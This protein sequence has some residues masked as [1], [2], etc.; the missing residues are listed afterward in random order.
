M[1]SIAAL[2]RIGRLRR[3]RATEMPALQGRWEMLSA[4]LTGAIFTTPFLIT[5]LA[6]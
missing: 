1:I 3:R 5:D 4:G 6:I 2:D